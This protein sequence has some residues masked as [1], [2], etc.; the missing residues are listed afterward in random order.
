M[1]WLP[2]SSKWAVC[3]AAEAMGARIHYQ[4][5]QPP[6]VAEPLITCPEDLEKLRVPD[7]E[8]TFPLNELLKATRIL[9]R[10][11]RGQ[12][13]INGRADQ[14]PIALALALCGP[15][16]FLML[17]MEPERESWVNHLLDLCS[18][19]NVALG[20]AQRRAGAHSSSIG[21]AGTSIISPALF[22]RFEGPRAAAFCRALKAEG[23]YPFVHACGNETHLL[24]SLVATGAAALEL[25]PGTDPHAC[26]QAIRGKTAVL[27]M[28]DP[29][30]ILRNGTRHEVRAHVRE[31]LRILSPGGGF[32]IGPGC[33]LPP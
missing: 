15:E 3:A 8:K 4:P 23:C 29:A 24:P 30:H 14:G 16:Q 20:L 19:M 12:V 18:Q 13:H 1:A 31:M 7:P 10:E 5:D 28:L 26:K 27:G 11:T 22:D 25:D 32:L 17:L 6:H 21:L 2:D 33:A 9:V